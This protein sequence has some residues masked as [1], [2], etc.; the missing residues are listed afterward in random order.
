MPLW[1]L[2]A[3]GGANALVWAAIVCRRPPPPP[4]ARWRRQL[5]AQAG[6]APCLLCW[7]PTHSW[8]QHV[9]VP[10]AVLE[11]RQQDI[12]SLLEGEW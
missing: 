6:K 11:R 4:V 5:D 2:L 9:R 12:E 10:Q 7:S 8:E 1:L 3:L